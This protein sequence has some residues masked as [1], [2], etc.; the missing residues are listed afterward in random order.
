VPAPAVAGTVREALAAA[1]QAVAAAGVETPRLD[2]ELLLAAALGVERARLAAEP[3]LAVDAAAGRRVGSMVRRRVAREPVAYILGRKGFR[4]LDLAVDNR[5]L[6]PR[7]ETELLVEAAIDLVPDAAPARILDVG[8]GSGAVAL[9]VADEIP[10]VEVTATDV[11][12]N[13][14]AVASANAT[15][16]G[17][18]ERVRFVPGSLPSGGRFDVVVANLP[19]VAEGELG[20]LAPELRHE[21]RTALVAGPTGLE[22]I[23]GLLGALA[24]GDLEAHAIALEVGAGQAAT[25]SDL[26][27]RAGF[28]SVHRLRDLAGIE[29]VVTGVG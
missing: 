3:D 13:A 21:P 1:T 23:E 4:R 9:A 18:D 19:Y 2:A 26:V 7:P 11:S 27:R 10:G 15:R 6:I 25:V 24:L 16:L 5:V 29:R 12:R 28:D 14:L 8:T 20:S 17:L 22:A